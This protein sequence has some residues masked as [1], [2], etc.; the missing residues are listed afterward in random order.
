M[1]IFKIERR[2]EASGVEAQEIKPEVTGNKSDTGYV[3]TESEELRQAKE[4]TGEEVPGSSAIP[5][6]GSE[7]EAEAAY[8]LGTA[9]TGKM[10]IKID[11]P[12]SKIFTEAL[13]KILAFENMTMVPLLVEELEELKKD[14]SFNDTVSIHVQAYDASE[15]TTNDVFEIADGITKTDGDDQ[16][17]AMEAIRHHSLSN[18][19]GRAE[20]FCRDTKTKS[21]YHFNAACYRIAS[22]AKAA[23]V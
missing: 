12:L 18:A 13:N 21:F 3:P 22:L 10:V 9:K 17:L 19:V 1:E 7:T 4:M 6:G 5:E 14:E 15:L 23:G 16:I 2:P 8:T 20:N 11:G